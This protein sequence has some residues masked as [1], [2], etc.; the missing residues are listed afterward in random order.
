MP[1]YNYTAISDLGK[2]IKGTIIADNPNDL[3]NKLI[4][5]GLEVIDFKIVGNTS[6]SLSL[7]S[8]VSKKDIILLCTHF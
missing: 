5:I 8:P 1:N 6:F 4:G 3:D 2:K 7:S